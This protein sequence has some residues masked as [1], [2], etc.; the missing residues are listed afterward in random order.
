MF[1]A[2][3]EVFIFKQFEINFRFINLQPNYHF[4]D[5]NWLLKSV[6]GST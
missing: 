6:I 3:Y 5:K 4:F 1:N 2:A